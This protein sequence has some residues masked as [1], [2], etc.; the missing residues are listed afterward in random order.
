MPRTESTKAKALFE[1]K[2]LLQKFGFDGFSFQDI[3]DKLGLRKQSLYVHFKSKEALANELINE[4]RAFQKNWTETVSYFKTE[5]QIGAWFEC[6][7]KYASDDLKYCS[8]AAFATDYNSLPKSAKKNLQQIYFDIRK[9]F[10]GVITQGQKDGVFRR[11][12]TADELTE[13]I[14]ALAFGGQQMAR[15]ANDSEQIKKR[16]QDAFRLLKATS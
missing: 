8:I 7:F 1:G 9:W 14:L 6:L 10:V 13:I 2:F 4:Y 15:L 11:D 16:Q 3:A 12:L 5:D